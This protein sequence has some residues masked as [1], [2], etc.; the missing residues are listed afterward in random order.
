M[1][2]MSGEAKLFQ[3]ARGEIAMLHL[4]RYN[5]FTALQT[6][7]RDLRSRIPGA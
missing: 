5:A 1:I 7:A 3:P 2:S 4:A 6:A